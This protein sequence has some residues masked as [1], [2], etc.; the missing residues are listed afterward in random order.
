MCT[1]ESHKLYTNF[2][3]YL[4]IAT[5]YKVDHLMNEIGIVLFAQVIGMK[6]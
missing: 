6:T 5:M 4:F 1:K 3:K 2:T